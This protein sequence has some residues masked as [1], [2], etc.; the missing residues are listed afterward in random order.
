MSFLVY[1]KEKCPTTNR[2]HYQTYCEFKTKQRMTAIKKLFGN[3]A[4]IE[5]RKGTQQQ[6]IDYCKKTESRAEDPKEFGEPK[7]SEQGKRNDIQDAVDA[8][9]KKNSI[10][11]V[12]M[13]HSTTFVKYHGGLSKLS[14]L[15]YNHRDKK[16][17]PTVLWIYGPSGCGKSR[18]AHTMSNDIYPKA[19]EHKWWDGYQQQE[20]II[21]D[22][23]KGAWPLEYLL[24]V[25]DR[26]PMYIEVK[27]GS[28][29]LNSPYIIITSLAKPTDPTGEISRR[30]KFMRMG[31]TVEEDDD[32]F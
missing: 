4:H 17:P 14:C 20:L 31:D 18:F 27:G 21:I 12:A 29:P 3:D 15:L 5:Q 7:V 2:V 23:Y 19:S 30:V 32:L 9:K 11:E 16:N 26:Y 1:Q 10:K 25:I 8:L 22:E 6:A 13:E 24:K 28:M